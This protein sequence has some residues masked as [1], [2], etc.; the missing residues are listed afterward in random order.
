MVPTDGF[1]AAQHP[2]NSQ[3]LEAFF[4][5]Q[6]QSLQEAF[7]NTIIKFRGNVE[8]TLRSVESQRESNELER[9]RSEQVN[10]SSHII[11]RKPVPTFFL[12]NCFVVG[13]VGKSHLGV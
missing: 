12:I 3:G 1:P 10:T 8:P 7:T 2:E 13:F 6:V 9:L 4:A 5:Q 11:R